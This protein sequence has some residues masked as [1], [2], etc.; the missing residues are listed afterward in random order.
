[1]TGDKQALEALE[2]DLA[3][4]RDLSQE[5]VI[6]LGL[7]GGADAKDTVSR[8]LKQA[9]KNDLAKKISWRG[10]NGKISF[11]NLHLK[12][13]VMGCIERILEQEDALKLHFSLVSSAEHCYAARLLNEMYSDKS[14]S[15]YMHFLRP[16]LMEVKTVNKYFQLETGDMLGVFRD[17]DRLYMSTLRRVVK[18][19]VLRMNNE[20]SQGT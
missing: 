17:L 8:I 4:Q 19:S 3:S 1:M 10:M 7:A 5:L 15:L 20:S 9:I 11:E 18:P 12:A 16:V 14:N 13:V 6:T 2:G